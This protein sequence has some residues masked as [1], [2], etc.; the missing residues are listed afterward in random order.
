MQVGFGESAKVKIVSA[1]GATG[2]TCTLVTHVY[3]GVR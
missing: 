3:I 2:F 1:E